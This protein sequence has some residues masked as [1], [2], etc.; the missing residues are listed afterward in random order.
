[1]I[2]LT[3][4]SVKMQKVLEAIRF[5]DK[6]HKGQKRKASGN[7]YFTHPLGASYLL[8]LFKVSKNLEDLLCAIILH[9]TIEDTKATY[10]L[11]LRKFGMLV[12]SLVFEMSSE[13]VE[14]A[15][16]GKLEYLKK[17]FQGY[18]S[19]ALVLKLIDRL[20]N[21][22]D[23]P[24]EKQMEETRILLDHTEKNRRLSGTHKKI[25]AEIRKYI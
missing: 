18:S 25:I 22:M 8:V 12:A 17:R 16:L 21:M 20:S 10:D 6:Y 15:K 23:K 14:K 11:I 7:D 1:M 4:R 13:P 5:A 9:D 24:S 3:Q 2:P 19:Y